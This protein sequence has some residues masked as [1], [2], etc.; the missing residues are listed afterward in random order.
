MYILKP[1]VEKEMRE[2]LVDEI[3]EEFTN[4]ESSNA[5]KALST[6]M[7]TPITLVTLSFTSHIAGTIIDFIGVTFMAVLLGYC[8]W[9]SMLA[10][11]FWFY[12]NQTGAFAD[13]TQEVDKVAKLVNDLFSTIMKQVALRKVV[14]ASKKTQ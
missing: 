6:Q 1:S 14:N 8:S 5:S 4:L 13:E 2:K 10:A 3:E 7:K 12:N 11:A 9:F